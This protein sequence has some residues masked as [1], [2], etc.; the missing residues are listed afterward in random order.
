MSSANQQNEEGMEN[1]GD[2][3]MTITKITAIT[4][5]NHLCHIA[6]SSHHDLSTTELEVPS[7]TWL[8]AI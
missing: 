6:S 5:T 8:K 4:F 7:T 3:Q 1:K 2:R